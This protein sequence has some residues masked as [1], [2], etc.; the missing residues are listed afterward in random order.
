MFNK[1]ICSATLLESRQQNLLLR[2]EGCRAALSPDT[3]RSQPGS[4][5]PHQDL[6]DF[7]HILWEF[8]LIRFMI[9]PRAQKKLWLTVPVGGFSQFHTHDRGETH[10]KGLINE[11]YYFLTDE[12]QKEVQECGKVLVKKKEARTC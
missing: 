10:C 12:Q 4:V 3:A 9:E 8:L 7:R 11:E 6:C 2:S 5:P 1:S